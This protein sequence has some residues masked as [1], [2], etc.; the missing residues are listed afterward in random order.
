MA[1]VPLL[2]STTSA[3][4]SLYR[5]PKCG[6]ASGEM[7]AKHSFQISVIDRRIQCGNPKCLTADKIKAFIPETSPSPLEST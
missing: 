4:V 7:S 3:G 5:C 1:F 2:A 6:K